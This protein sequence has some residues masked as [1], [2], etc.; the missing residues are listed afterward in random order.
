LVSSLSPF[1]LA[2]VAPTA[3]HL[4]ATCRDDRGE[5]HG[6]RPSDSVPPVPSRQ[7]GSVEVTAPSSPSFRSSPAG[8]D[9]LMSKRLVPSATPRLPD[10]APCGRP[11]RPAARLGSGDVRSGLCCHGAPCMA[12]AAALEPNSGAPLS[13]PDRICAIRA[14]LGVGPAAGPRKSNRNLFRAQQ[15]CWAS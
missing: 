8:R 12:H 9:S 6:L 13:N 5:S 11:S 10:P 4:Q 15:R 7:R 14:P 3:V 2:R 1:L